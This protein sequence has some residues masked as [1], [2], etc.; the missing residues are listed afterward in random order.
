MQIYRSNLTKR[1]L[2]LVVGALESGEYTQCRGF[3]WRMVD[4]NP[5]GSY[6]KSHCCLN[7]AATVLN[8]PNNDQ[9]RGTSTLKR[10]FM[11]GLESLYNAMVHWNDLE[12]LS[13]QEIAD[14]LKTCEFDDHGHA[15]YSEPETVPALASA[16]PVGEP[17][18]GK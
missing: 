18:T 5:D 16:V 10:A 11:F 8:F 14:R 9:T 13:F 4:K 6:R 15:Y 7:V 17:L 12:K 1:Q 3:F 2:D